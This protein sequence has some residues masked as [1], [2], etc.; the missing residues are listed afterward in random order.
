MSALWTGLASLISR[1]YLWLLAVA[2]V[3]TGVF[4]IGVPR[5]KFSTG[6]DTIVSPSSQVYQDNLRYQRQFGGDPALVLFEG[7]VRQLFSEGN[8]EELAGLEAELN[9]TG[10]YQAVL[11]PLTVLEFARDQIELGGVLAPAALAREQDAAAAQARQEAAAAGAS[12]AEQE[13]AAEAARDRLAREFSERHAVDAQRLAQAGEQS[14]ENPRFVDFLIFDEQGNVRSDMRGTFPDEQHALM[15]VRLNGNMTIDEQ[16]EAAADAVDLVNGHTFEGLS[17]LPSGSPLLLKEINDSMQESMARMAL[18][19]GAIMVVVLL[20]VFQARWRLV[21]LPVVLI[22]CLWAFGL[23]GFLDVPLTMVTISGLPIFI[24]LGVDFAI[25]LH[26]RF[27]EEGERSG[28]AAAGLRESMRNLGP[29]LSIAV[30]VAAVGFLAM[31]FS[32]V[33]MIRDFGLMLTVGVVVLFL[34]GLMLLQS[35]LFAR[36][37]NRRA[38]ATR[39]SRLARWLNVEQGTAFVTDWAVRRALAVVAAGVLVAAAGLLLDERIP[40]E[41]DPERFVPQDSHVLDELERIRL[42]AGSSSELGLMIEADDVIQPDVLA[43][44]AGYERRMLE[45][46]PRELLR[47]GSIA[48][49]VSTVTEAPPTAEEAEAVLAVAPDALT[50]TFVSED[51]RLAH[52]IFAVG[53]IS[54][55]E[56]ERLLDEMQAAFDAPDGVTVTASG[57]AVVGIEAVHAL[58]ANRPVMTY[59]ALGAIFLALLLLYRSPVKAGAPLVAVLVAVGAS[60]AVLYLSGLDL[61]PLT[62]VSGPLIIAMSTEFSVIMMSRYFEERR[63]GL[64]PTEAMHTAA[65]RI[66]RAITASGLTATGGFA[67][68]AFSGFP[69]LDAF[70]KV[71][72]LNIGLSL[73]SSLIVLPPLLVWLDERGLLRLMAQEAVDR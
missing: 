47:S 40:I 14:I 13:A 11:S 66:G 59:S 28:A 55:T 52:I 7:E 25:Q 56:R 36:D 1:R 17:V 50:R 27:E 20:F 6:Q 10:L 41:T 45:E 49:T 48:S 12:P 32:R 2:L 64:A 23:L 53:A 15:V 3:A 72:A 73:L 42:V 39:P 62:S 46:H 61:N 33:P 58:T 31:R 51:R 34:A 16:G 63:R 38:W 21:S 57:L 43:W 37:R 68:L 69:L 54:L 65:M 35:V 19:A 24:G 70:G 29:A 9:E 5:L 71:T 4:A 60:S 67:V 8:R 30:L 18:L 26:Y 44:M 22:G